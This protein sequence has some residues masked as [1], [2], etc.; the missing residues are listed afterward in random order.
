VD[1]PARVDCARAERVGHGA[2]RTAFIPTEDQ[3]SLVLGLQPPDSASLEH[4]NAVL[5]KATAIVRPTHCVGQVIEIASILA[6][7]RQRLACFQV[8]SQCLMLQKLP[9]SQTCYA[10]G[11]IATSSRR[12]ERVAYSIN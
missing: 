6:P 10:V 11:G 7:E 8:L 9:P 5:A 1:P 3:G 12:Q 2:A 4:T